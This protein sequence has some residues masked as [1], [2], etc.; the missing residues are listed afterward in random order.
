MFAARI[1]TGAVWLAVGA[2]AL[3]A[4]Y[5]CGDAAYALGS[6]LGLR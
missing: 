6:M 1:L 3:M 4:A 5:G 2:T